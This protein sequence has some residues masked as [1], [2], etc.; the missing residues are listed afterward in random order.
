MMK[1]LI[2]ALLTIS[3]ISSIPCS[4][5]YPGEFTIPLKKLVQR[6]ERRIFLERATA[7]AAKFVVAPA[8]AGIAL[9][10]FLYRQQ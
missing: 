4:A 1:K 8:A 3:M 9:L 7:M 5:T 10:L 2:L 6:L